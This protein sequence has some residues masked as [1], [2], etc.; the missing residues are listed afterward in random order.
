LMSS[1]GPQAAPALFRS[2]RAVITLFLVALLWAAENSAGDE[3]N[4]VDSNTRPRRPVTVA[5]MIRMTEP[6][7]IGL[8]DDAPFAQ[9]SPDGKKFV[10]ILRNGN[11][12]KNTNEYSLLLWRTDELP[13]APAP[14]RLLTMS[15]SSN[16][17]GIQQ[18]TW[19]PDNETIVFLGERPGE[20]H[21]LYSFTISTHRL[22]KLTN[23]RTSLLSYSI[24][25]DGKKIAFTA[26]EPI[27]A[28]FDEKAQHEGVLVSTQYLSTLIRNEKGGRYFGKYQSFLQIGSRRDLPIRVPDTISPLG[29]NLAISPNGKSIAIRCYVDNVPEIWKEYS[30]VEM[31][32]L[33][34]KTVGPGQHSFLNRYVLLNT[35]TGESSILLDSPLSG[36]NDSKIIWS[37][38]SRSVVITDAYLPLDDTT[39]EERR[40]RRSTAFAVEVNVRTREIAKISSDEMQVLNWES[41]SNRLIFEGGERWSTGP[42]P[43][44]AFEKIKGKWRE[45]VETTTAESQPR[46]ELEQDMNVPPKIYAVGTAMK[47]KILLLDLNPQFGEL[48]I[49]KVEAIHWKGSDGHEVKGGL[50]YPI[51]YKTG[52]RYPLVIQNHGFEPN[53]FAMGPGNSAFVAQPLAGNDVFVLQIAF[54]TDGHDV[55]NEAGLETAAYEGAIDYLDGLGLIDREHVGLGGFSR[56]GLHVK[57][58]LTHSKYHFVAATVTDDTDGGYFQYLVNMNSYV[59][60]AQDF[61]QI[62]GGAPFGEGLKSWFQRSPGFNVDK[63]ETPVRIL[64]LSPETLLYEWEWFAALYRLAKPV[65]MIYIPDGQHE[66]QRPWDRLIAQQGNVEWFTFWLNGKEDSSPTKTD[67]YRRWR[68]MRGET[69][70]GL[71]GYPTNR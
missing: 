37:P 52:R 70:G 1:V 36:N 67:Q 34:G 66:L 5:D 19:L 50:Y 44:I 60:F 8:G 69:A 64:A 62:N 9:F 2:V 16:R 47:R 30:D 65:E 3:M 55:P 20:L 41:K 26:E 61:E 43:T 15:S 53:R 18:L 63:V 31:A 48:N 11:L 4:Q 38:D 33:T 32:S 71:V 28:I 68:K 35:A 25:G 6:G 17:R 57:Y 14:E 22:T 59:G 29:Y 39:P 56:T 49:A 51:H 10:V 13:S 7:N 46:I 24:T 54:S 45:V 58:A 42:R 21:Q 12:E 23:H 27:G 40:V